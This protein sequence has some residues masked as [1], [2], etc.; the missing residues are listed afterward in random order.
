MAGLYLH[1]PPPPADALSPVHKAAFTEA[2]CTELSTYATTHAGNETLEA[3]LIGGDIHTISYQNMQTL[4]QAIFTSFDGSAIQEATVNIQP[5]RHALDAFQGYKALGF[6]RINIL[7]HSF[8]DEDLERSQARHNAHQVLLS[9]EDAQKAGFQRIGITLL[10]DID[11]QPIEYWG[12]NLEKITHLGIDHVVFDT[13]GLA[14][15]NVFP[16]EIGQTLYFP[17]LLED[18]YDRYGFAVDY[19]KDAG[20]EQYTLSSFARPDA[21]S[22]YT[23]LH[24]QHANLLG[25]GPGAHSFWWYGASQSRAHRWANVDNIERYGALLSQGELPIDTRSLLSLDE[26]ANEFT[27]LGLSA[28]SGLNLETLETDYGVDLLMEH[29]DEIAWLE[30]QDL[31]EPLRNNHVYLTRTGKLHAAEVTNRLLLDI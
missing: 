2:L 20:F 29:I 9:I 31:I 27:V 16:A 5:G 24:L 1:I 18:A 28:A 26:L 23:R 8:F 15:E 4:M 25:I 11:Q 14:N 3:L 10:I 13:R 12:A 30:S 6:D 7:A 19:L 22:C 17:A 21:Q